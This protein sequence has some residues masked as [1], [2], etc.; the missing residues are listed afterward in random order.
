MCE[1]E[2]DRDMDMDRMEEKK[3]SRTQHIENNLA[4][5]RLWFQSVVNVAFLYE[6]SF[7]VQLRFATKWK[8]AVRHGHQYHIHIRSENDK[9]KYIH[10][11]AHKH[12]GTRVWKM[13]RKNT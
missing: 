8:C 7:A 9:K 1:R 11:Q 10:I 13:N 3:I 5:F 4:F 6:P 2:R 12:T